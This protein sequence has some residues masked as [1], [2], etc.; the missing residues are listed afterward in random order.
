MAKLVKAS[1]LAHIQDHQID[2]KVFSQHCVDWS[3][4]VLSISACIDVSVPEA[5]V[6]VKILGTSIGKCVLS[7]SHQDCKIG[8]SVDGFKAE[9]KLRIDGNCLKVSA[10]VCAPIVGC[11]KW[12]HDLFCW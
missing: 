11:K 12:E 7:P 3:V 1:G 8:G 6:D 10:E 2:D 4:W 5:N 9:V